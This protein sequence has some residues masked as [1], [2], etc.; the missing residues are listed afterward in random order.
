MVRAAMVARCACIS[1]GESSNSTAGGSD[2][3]GARAAR[4]R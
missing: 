3:I 4:E 2:I 1:G